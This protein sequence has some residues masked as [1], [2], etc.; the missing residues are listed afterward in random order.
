MKDTFKKCFCF[1]GPVFT[2]ESQCIL[3]SNSQDCF[4]YSLMNYGMLLPPPP[5]SG[6]FFRH[7]FLSIPLGIWTSFSAK[8]VSQ[9]GNVEPTFSIWAG[10]RGLKA[11][12]QKVPEYVS[13]GLTRHPPDPPLRT[14]LCIQDRKCQNC[15][16][17]SQDQYS[18]SYSLKR[19]IENIYLFVCVCF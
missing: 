13:L 8:W 5:P 17:V 10:K 19:E 2:C 4:F 18:E 6:A 11:K 14:P 3:L 7:V 1:Q 15:I 12:R 16:Y 9:S